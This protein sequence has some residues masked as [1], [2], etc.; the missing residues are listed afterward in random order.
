MKRFMCSINSYDYKIVYMI[1]GHIDDI[2]NIVTVTKYI[3]VKCVLPYMNWNINNRFSSFD[4]YIFK[5]SVLTSTNL[6]SIQCNA[7]LYHVYAMF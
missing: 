6:L 7:H 2:L 1:I 4:T 5:I 3:I